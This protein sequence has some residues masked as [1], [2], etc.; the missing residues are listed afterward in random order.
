[1]GGRG[2]REGTVGIHGGDRI[3]GEGADCACHGRRR[4]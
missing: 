3:G 4:R 2:V 1:M